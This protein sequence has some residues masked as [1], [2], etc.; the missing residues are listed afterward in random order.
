MVGVL[1]FTNA[2][3]IVADFPQV[4]FDHCVL[5]ELDLAFQIFLVALLVL[6]RLP[7]V[8]EKLGFH[9][10]DIGKCLLH[11]DEILRHALDDVGAQ[12][13]FRQL[14][15]ALGKQGGFVEG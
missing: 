6:L 1:A 7:G 13:Y 14:G 9:L 10:G 5:M 3:V 12:P 4:H 11:Q 8:L 15:Q 2:E